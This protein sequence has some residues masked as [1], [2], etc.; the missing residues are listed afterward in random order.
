MQ[1]YVYL[2]VLI[3][4][5]HVAGHVV[6]AAFRKGGVLDIADESIEARFERR[7]IAGICNAAGNVV[8]LMPHPEHAVEAGF[9][10]DSTEGPRSGVDGLPFF[11]SVVSGML[12]R[13]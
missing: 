8:G 6:T 4:D 5:L 3:L 9:G 7:D 10:P 13:A 12:A 2:L 11:T 1:R